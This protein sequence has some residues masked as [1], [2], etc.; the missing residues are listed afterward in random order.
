VDWLLVV[1]LVENAL[2]D[3]LIELT[4]MTNLGRVPAAPFRRADVSHVESCSGVV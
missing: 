3:E 2:M 1:A 4:L